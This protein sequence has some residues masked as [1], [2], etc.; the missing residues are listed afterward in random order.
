[1]RIDKFLAQSTGL[2]RKEVQ[3]LVQRGKVSLGDTVV[4]NAAMHIDEDADLYLDGFPVEA[5]RDRY[6]MLYKPEGFVCANKDGV[7]PTVL[8]LIDLPRADELT[9]CGR[10][11][12]DTTGLVLITSDG[13]WAHRIT[14]PKHKAEKRYYVTTAEEIAPETIELFAQG[15]LL[16]G[17]TKRTLPA[18]LEITAPNEAIITL[19]E[20]RYHQVKRM[21]AAA[22]N[23]VTALH[24]QQIGEIELDEMI[25]PGEWR[26][27][28]T[29]E[30]AS[31]Q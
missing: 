9:I 26:E 2:S 11:D 12:V 16:K 15:L 17:E 25:D 20:G 21:F 23:R 6:L 22:N 14:S 3:K 30:V 4:K 18:K 8:S 27:L 28:T 24:R 10:L 29:E 5:P 7:H 19:Q 31:I 13:Q 1:M